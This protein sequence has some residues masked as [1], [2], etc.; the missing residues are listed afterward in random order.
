MTAPRI[1][2]PLLF[3]ACICMV[4]G[5]RSISHRPRRRM[6]FML[7]K[8]LWP[9]VLAIA[10]SCTSVS[11]DVGG[12]GVVSQC[13]VVVGWAVAVSVTNG[14]GLDGCRTQ[15]LVRWQ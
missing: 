8:R 14:W 6:T 15:W 9:L 5:V 4:T 3:T 11:R 7:A 1:L 12:G 2:I 13:C 10:E